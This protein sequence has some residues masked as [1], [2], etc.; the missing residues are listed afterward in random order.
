[1]TVRSPSGM[2]SFFKKLKKSLD[3]TST[4]PAPKIGRIPLPDVGEGELYLHLDTTRDFDDEGSIESD[5]LSSPQSPGFPKRKES[6]SI[7]RGSTPQSRSASRTSSSSYPH[8]PTP[9]IVAPT[10]RWNV[11]ATLRE[12]GWKSC[13][14]VG[15]V[16][17]PGMFKDRRSSSK[18][19]PSTTSP[20]PPPST[21]SLSQLKERTLS[22]A[23]DIRH[24]PSRPRP[25]ASSSTSRPPPTPL[26][27][28]ITERTLTPQPDSL[29]RP[30]KGILKS[31]MS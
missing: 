10:P 20:S 18:T 30:L 22:P 16:A 29:K 26:S 28:R 7:S 4:P 11:G 25:R 14:P 24:I 9:G 23:S 1:M 31:S 6:I 12:E 8:P 19:R 17:K 2:E 21:A 13:T 15:D 5:R 27:S 3:I